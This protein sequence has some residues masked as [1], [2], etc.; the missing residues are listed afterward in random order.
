MFPPPATTWAS[1]QIKT[2]TTIFPLCLTSDTDPFSSIPQTWAIYFL[3]HMRSCVEKRL[4]VS[5]EIKIKRWKKYRKKIIYEKDFHRKSSCCLYYGYCS[6]CKEGQFYWLIWNSCRPVRMIY[7]YIFMLC[8]N[9][10]TFCQFNYTCTCILM[11]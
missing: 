3:W 7:F 11:I 10:Q 6:T 4:P 2:Y 8:V 1:H 9:L 5:Q